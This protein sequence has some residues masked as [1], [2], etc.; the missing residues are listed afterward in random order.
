MKSI[1]K[2]KLKL[3]FVC[4]S[5]FT[6]EGIGF[7][8]HSHTKNCQI[9]ETILKDSS[10]NKYF[11]ISSKNQHPVKIYDRRNFL[12]NCKTIN[13]NGLEHPILSSSLYVQD[14][15]NYVIYFD[16]KYVGHKISIYMYDSRT[17][18][19]A[20]IYIYN[21]YNV[22]KIVKSKFGFLID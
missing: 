19:Y 17:G 21:N 9:I 14:S 6:Q 13:V 16:A 8:K 22:Y 10:V 4:I 3:F 7:A 18:C 5:L 1:F 20:Y 12:H 11:S 2:H 15:T